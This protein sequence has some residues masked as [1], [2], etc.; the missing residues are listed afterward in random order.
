[1]LKALIAIGEIAQLYDKWQ[2]PQR[3]LMPRN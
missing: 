1:M 2:L 3:V